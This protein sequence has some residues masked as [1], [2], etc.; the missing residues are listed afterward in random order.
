MCSKIKRIFFKTIKLYI[1]AKFDASE[2][3][4]VN[5]LSILIGENI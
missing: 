5:I 4:D 2:F 1:L 3:V